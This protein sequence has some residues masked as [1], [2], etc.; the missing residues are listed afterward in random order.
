[1]LMV[2]FTQPE[3]FCMLSQR[4]PPRLVQHAVWVLKE[5]CDCKNTPLRSFA[6]HF[7]QF[8]SDFGMLRHALASRCGRPLPMLQRTQ[9]PVVCRFCVSQC[10]CCSQSADKVEDVVVNDAS[11]D[12]T[13]YTVYIYILYYTIL[14]Y[15]SQ[16]S[17]IAPV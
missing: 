1:M 17:N 16:T 15:Y 9:L 6:G 5:T 8:Q 10:V 11:L 7:W 2:S 13:C 12:T 3:G 4:A 14:L